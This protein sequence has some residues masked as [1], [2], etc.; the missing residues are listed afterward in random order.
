M[1]NESLLLLIERIKHAAWG[2]I[3]AHNVTAIRGTVSCCRRNNWLLAVRL[4][5]IALVSICEHLVNGSVFW[6]LR[7]VS[8]G[9]VVTIQAQILLELVRRHLVWGLS[10]DMIRK[11]VLLWIAPLLA[12]L[13]PLA[14]LSERFDLLLLLVVVH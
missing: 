12:R 6:V 2:T 3:R 9:I 7:L 11:D 13:P 4:L 14:R 10:I 8:Y 5:D 1:F